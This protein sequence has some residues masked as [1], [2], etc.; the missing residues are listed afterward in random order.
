MMPKNLVTLAHD[1]RPERSRSRFLPIAAI[2]VF[3]LA[4]APLLRESVLVCYS[5]WCEIMGKS[6]DVRT[7]ILDSIQDRFQAAR[8]GLWDSIT[9]C[10]NRVPWD[11]KVVLCVAVVV[12]S[13]AMVMLRR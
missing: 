2:F 8:D 5:Q 1:L 10:F 9:P 13:L 12:M 11:L 6:F 7:P 3:S 4:L